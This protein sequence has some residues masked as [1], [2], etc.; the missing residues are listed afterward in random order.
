MPPAKRPPPKRPAKRAAKRAGPPVDALAEAAW[1]EADAALAEALIECDRARSAKT[2]DARDEALSLLQLA[3]GRAARRR[4]LSR[5]G[6][7]GGLEDFDAGR[8]ELSARPKRAP[9]RVRIVDE[10]VSRGRE[11]LIKARVT[12]ARAKRK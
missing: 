2:S 11:V 7:A 8:H 4:G 5:I 10:G 12:A 3:L 1:T 9:K 6:K